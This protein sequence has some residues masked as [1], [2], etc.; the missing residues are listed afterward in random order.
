MDELN[1]L[2]AEIQSTS[3]RV[4]F[5][6]GWIDHKADQGIFTTLGVSPSEPLAHEVAAAYNAA[7]S[8]AFTAGWF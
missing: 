4:A 7:H 8:K 5:Y 1:A 2:I 6:R 3:V